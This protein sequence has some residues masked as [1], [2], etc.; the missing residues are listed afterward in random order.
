VRTSISILAALLAMASLAQSGIL[1][2]RLD[3]SLSG[4]GRLLSG[5]TTYTINFSEQF[6]YQNNA[7]VAN[8]TSELEFPL[9]VFVTEVTFSMGAKLVKNLPWSLNVAYATNADNPR[10]RMKDSDWLRIPLFSFDEK[11][12][13]SESNASLKANYLN[14]YGRATVWMAKEARVDVML[15][16]KYQKLSF[17]L[18][19]LYGWYLDDS[20]NVQYDTSY[21]GKLVGTYE[22]K[23][24]MPYIGMATAFNIISRLGLDASVMGSSLVSSSD[25]DDHVLRNKLSKSNGTGAMLNVDGGLHYELFGPGHG[26]SWVF[27]LGY[28]FMYISCSGTQ[29][30]SWYGDDP[31]TSEDDTGTGFSGIRYKVK[32]SQHGLYMN[33]AGRF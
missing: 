22:V 28:E 26:L 2:D 29:N 7:V 6:I 21:I 13:Y 3:L 24:H 12:V 23:Y 1:N 11:I 17:D 8:A 32:S 10:N 20:L 4:R 30:Q 18:K 9:D 15:G 33:L 19:D 14:I 27:G 31:I 16:Y 5:H 25:T